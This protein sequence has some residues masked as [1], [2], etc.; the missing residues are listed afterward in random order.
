[1]PSLKVLI[2]AHVHNWME[3]VIEDLNNYILKGNFHEQH[4]LKTEQILFR[5]AKICKIKYDK[6]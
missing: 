3:N 1:M 2:K 4:Y 5:V 6:L